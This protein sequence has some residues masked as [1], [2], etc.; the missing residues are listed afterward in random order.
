MTEPR[1]MVDE[2]HP[3]MHDWGWEVEHNSSRHSKWIN[4]IL[5]IHS[6][7]TEQEQIGKLIKC[8]I[9]WV[10]LSV[11]ITEALLIAEYLTRDESDREY[12]E[13]EYTKNYKEKIMF[14]L[15]NAEK[16]FA[17]AGMRSTFTVDEKESTI[18]RI[19]LK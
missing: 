7:I 4:E 15:S 12:I 9:Q 13:D 3:D 11:Q 8:L 1:H 16:N 19:N 2:Y 10:E 14:A 5:D 17:A 18:K 6:D